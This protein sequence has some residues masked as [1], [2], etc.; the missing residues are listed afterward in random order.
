[1]C[2]PFFLFKKDYFRL[3]PCRAV[4]LGCCSAGFEVVVVSDVMAGNSVVS[5]S[6]VACF[7]L[8]KSG[9]LFTECPVLVSLSK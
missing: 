2:A 4:L 7:P 1:M 3:E 6:V 8:S 9:V 5:L